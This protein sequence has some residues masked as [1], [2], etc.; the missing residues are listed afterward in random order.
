[1]SAAADDVTNGIFQLWRQFRFSLI[2]RCRNEF[3]QCNPDWDCQIYTGIWPGS[4]LSDPCTQS[5][6]KS[7]WKSLKNIENHH[8]IFCKFSW[9]KTLKMREIHMP[10]NTAKFTSHF[11]LFFCIWIS[12]N[13]HCFLHMNFTNI[14]QIPVFAFIAIYYRFAEITRVFQR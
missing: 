1:M 9:K 7:S 10:K 3:F 14:S 8:T 5:H 6:K 2:S 4:R 11:A 12:R 13:S